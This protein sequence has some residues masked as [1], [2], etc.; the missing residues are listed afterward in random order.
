[1]AIVV[2]E[3][4]VK[5]PAAALAALGVVAV[6]MYVGQDD[7]GKNMN[8][9]SVN[10]YAAVDIKSITNFEF[11]AAQATMGFD[12]GVIDAK[13]G[14]AQAEACGMPAWAPTLFSVD[15]NVSLASVIPYF[16]GAVSVLGLGRV[17]V[18]GDFD[19]VSGLISGRYATF[20]WQ[21]VAW[22]N[23]EVDLAQIQ[24]FQ[25][26]TQ[27][28]GVDIDLVEASITDIAWFPGQ[29]SPTPYTPPPVTYTEV[30]FTMKLPT[31]SQA[32]PGPSA[33]Y[34]EVLQALL[35]VHTLGGGAAVLGVDGSFG[36]ATTARL[37][38]FQGNNKLAE[39]GIAGPLTWAKLA[40]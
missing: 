33:L 1:M 29:P 24:L 40:A 32:A 7:S 19:I 31:I 18:Y 21:T 20:G 22:S 15:A 38:Q 5:L 11:G 17:G 23:G 36:A 28:D 6:S 12:Q 13:L 2:D 10:A 39:D 3:A 25:P 35:N 37:K 30:P 34:V 27:I 9:A 8:A 26:G 4:W 14:L 16:N